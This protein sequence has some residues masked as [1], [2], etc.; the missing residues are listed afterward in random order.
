MEV[1]INTVFN[2][3]RGFSQNDSP[4]IFEELSYE[5]QDGLI[6]AYLKAL[7]ADHC[8]E[9]IQEIGVDEF[10]ESFKAWLITGAPLLL[11]WARV[12]IRQLP[13]VRDAIQSQIDQGFA[14]EAF[15]NEG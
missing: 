1:A 8:A 2:G 7:P 4:P 3:F 5:D 6:D 13:G 14:E 15:S 11:E 12:R 10:D 9:L